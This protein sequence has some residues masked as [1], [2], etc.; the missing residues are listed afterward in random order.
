[1]HYCSCI[2]CSC[3][4]LAD[5]C[6]YYSPFNILYVK[7][8]MYIVYIIAINA[9]KVS[10]LK[11]RAFSM[12]SLTVYAFILPIHAI[13]AHHSSIYKLYVMSHYWMFWISSYC[14]IRTSHCSN[15]ITVIA[16]NNL[17]FK[18]SN[19]TYNSLIHKLWAILYSLKNND[20]W[21][22]TYILMN[23]EQLLHASARWMHRQSMHSQ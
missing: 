20:S 22:I 6:K 19:K 18:A 5:A 11:F 3:I 2:D 17:K 14:M 23:G 13:I 9:L 10:A 7:F 15:S 16:C 4:H 1:M 12:N 21:H 8:H